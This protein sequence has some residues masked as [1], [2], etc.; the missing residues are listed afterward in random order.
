[1]Y[2]NR[3][4]IERNICT[5]ARSLH[6]IHLPHRMTHL[7]AGTMYRVITTSATQYRDV[8]VNIALESQFIYSSIFSFAVS[9]LISF[10]SNRAL[11]TLNAH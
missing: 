8:F 11:E 6:Y 2:K 3:K 1:M 4:F 5:L 10:L 9:T 7:W